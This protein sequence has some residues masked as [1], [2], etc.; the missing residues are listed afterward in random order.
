MFTPSSNP[1]E[2]GLQGDAG[3]GST[4]GLGSL[5][6]YPIEQGLRDLVGCLR[7]TALARRLDVYPIEQGLQG[8]D[9][10]R[11]CFGQLAA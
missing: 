1:I 10:I 7:P 5:D 2:Q 9:A 4:P 8:L 6:V 11:L 3:G